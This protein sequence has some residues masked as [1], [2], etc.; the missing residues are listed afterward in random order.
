LIR[1]LYL[2]FILPLLIN[3]EDK[4][5]DLKKF[6]DPFNGWGNIAGGFCI[7]FAFILPNIAFM[8]FVLNWL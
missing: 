1:K 3:S 7:S 5:T 2:R 6:D 4:M 8:H